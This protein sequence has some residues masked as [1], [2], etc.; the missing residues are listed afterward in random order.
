M[1]EGL[2]K[3]L[4]GPEARVESAGLEPM[5]D[6]ASEEAVWVMKTLFGVDISGHRPRSVSDVILEG[7]DFIIA[8]DFSIYSRLKAMDQIPEEKLY[9]WDIEDPFGQGVGAYVEAVQRIQERLDRFL[10]SQ[11]VE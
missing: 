9:G 2:A 8:L 6:R 5:A 3:K 11:N 7:F 1:A 4:L 10:H